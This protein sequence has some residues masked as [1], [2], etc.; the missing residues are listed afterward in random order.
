MWLI[1]HGGEQLAVAAEYL[2]DGLRT[3]QQV[4]YA[5]PSTDDSVGGCRHDLRIYDLLG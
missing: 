3:G 2:A 5:A 4:L 1:R